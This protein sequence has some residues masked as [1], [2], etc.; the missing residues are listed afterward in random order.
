M[1][2]QKHAIALMVGIWLS[3]FAAASAEVPRLLSYQAKNHLGE[4]A[5]V[6]GAE[7]R[8]QRQAQHHHWQLLPP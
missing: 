6:C 7:Y 2:K 5:T 1:M 3:I 4:N 8:W